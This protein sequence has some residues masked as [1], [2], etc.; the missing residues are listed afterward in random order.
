[1]KI[2]TNT[3]FDLYAVD[4]DALL[5]MT[6]WQW[7]KKIIWDFDFFKFMVRSWL[8][9]EEFNKDSF[10]FLKDTEPQISKKMSIYVTGHGMKCTDCGLYSNMMYAKSNVT[11]V[12]MVCDKCFEKEKENGKYY[13][14]QSSILE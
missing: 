9:T 8:N 5:K 7:I 12:L 14:I 13:S 3:C 11:S 10:N 4:K 1:M 2:K 6:K